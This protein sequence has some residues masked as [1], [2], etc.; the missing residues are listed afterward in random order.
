M[1]ELNV[2]TALNCI[3]N[4]VVKV[5]LVVGVVIVLMHVGLNG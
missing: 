5:L 3:A 2:E 1:F 4:F